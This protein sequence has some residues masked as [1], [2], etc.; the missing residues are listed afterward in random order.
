MKVHADKKSYVKP[1]TLRIG[2]SVL[3]KRPVSAS[4]SDPSYES[5]PMAVSSKKGSMITA[6][7]E[8]R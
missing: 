6:Q 7:C 4:K 1:C 8:G 3:V 5:T 2:E